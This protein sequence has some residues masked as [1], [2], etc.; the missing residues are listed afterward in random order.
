VNRNLWITAAG[1]GTA[2]ILGWAFVPRWSY[3]REAQPLQFNHVVHTGTAGQS[4]EDCHRFDNDG[5]FVGVPSLETCVACHAEPLGSSPDERQLVQ[6]YI[7]PGREIPWLVD[8]RQPDLAFFPHATH[9]RLA[10]LPCERCHGSRGTSVA[11]AAVER[12]RISGYSR[13][14]LG[15]DGIALA[16]ANG[17]PMRMSDC[18]DCH[19]KQHVVESCLDCHK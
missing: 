17:P 14:V 4:C 13:A 15:R 11:L 3:D 19:R 6:D 9:V 7:R 8:A 1:M 18:S 2:C 5:R 16:A 10:K 12:N